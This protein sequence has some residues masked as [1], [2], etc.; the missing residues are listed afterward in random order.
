MKYKSGDDN[1]PTSRRGQSTICFSLSAPRAEK[2]IN[3][4]RKRG[5]HRDSAKNLRFTNPPSRRPPCDN[6]RHPNN[7][8]GNTSTEIRSGRTGTIQFSP[9]QFKLRGNGTV[10][11]YDCDQE[12]YAGAT[13]NTRLCT[14]QPIKAKKKVPLLE[15]QE[16][17]NSWE[18]NLLSKES[19]TSRGSVLQENDGWQ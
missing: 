18:K 13:K 11:T 14:N 17:F 5:V 15:L 2:S 8:A 7:R 4:R 12:C 19:G 10:G 16:Q 9:Y 6:I 3:N 1:P